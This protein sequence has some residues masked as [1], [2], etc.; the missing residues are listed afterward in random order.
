MQPKLDI[1]P[2]ESYIDEDILIKVT[3]CAANTE[4]TI[5]A[6]TYDEKDKKFTSH[7][8][9]LANEQGVVDVASQKPIEGTYDEID[10]SGL[11]WSMHADAKIDD[12]YEKYNADNISVTLFLIVD[13]I[14][15]DS[16]TITRYFYKTGTKKESVQ[17]EE[18]KG[19]LFYPAVKG[20][21]PAV[22]ILSGSDGGMQ[23]H[24]AAL[25][26]SKGYVTLALAYFGMEGVP[27]DLENIPLEYFQKA[28]NWLQEHPFVNGEIHLIGYS[29]G[30][31]LA[32]LLGATFD[33]YASIVAGV[34]SAYRTA[35]M[36]NGTFAPVTAWTHN[37]EALSQ[38]KFNYSISTMFSMFKNWLLKRPISFLSIWKNTLKNEAKNSQARIPVENINAPIMFIAGGDDQLWPS[39]HFVKKMEERLKASSN[40]HRY[41]YYENA[42]HFLAFPYS[43]VN[44]PA[45]V[46]MVIGGGMTMTFGGS[47][48]ANANAARDSW[49]EILAFVGEHSSSSTIGAG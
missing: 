9:F 48:A 4:V 25:L 16:A 43:F 40:P 27:K 35:G 3:G 10:A 20:E 12:Y 8:T 45:N 36:K 29:R 11:F 7:A 30:G 21:Y 6:I 39:A 17:F 5:Q 31:E 28:T 34:P 41:L 2:I 46:Y 13:G 18:V 47:K 1:S 19:T 23:E 37:E 44:L 42:G 49:R 22:I 38:M 15:V 26:A 32:L 14:Q 24:A 33:S